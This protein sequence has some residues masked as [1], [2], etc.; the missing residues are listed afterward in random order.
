M[1]NISINKSDTIGALSSGLCMIHCIATPFF[2]FATAC[3]TSCCSTAPLWW[4]WL[5]YIFLIISFIAIRQSALS[6]NNKLII[7]ALWICWM[8]LFTSILNLNFNWITMS[9]NI[10]FIPAFFLIGLHFYNFRY[11]RSNTNECC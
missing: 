10:K 1:L 4:R 9:E 2:F 6:S 8:G 11:C 7:S 5:D 3:S